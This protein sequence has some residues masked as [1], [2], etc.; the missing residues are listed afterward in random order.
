MVDCQNKKIA[1]ISAKEAA[2]LLGW[3]EDELE[4]YAWPEGFCNTAGPFN[5]WGGSSMSTF[6]MEAWLAPDKAL[7]F[8]NGKRVRITDKFIPS[9]PKWIK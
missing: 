5:G 2:E 6:T 9:V 8:C 4:Y 1:T 7:V 3:E